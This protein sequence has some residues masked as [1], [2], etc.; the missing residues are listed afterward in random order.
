MLCN[1]LLQHCRAHSAP[2]RGNRGGFVQPNKTILMHVKKMQTRGWMRVDPHP[3]LFLSVSPGTSRDVRVLTEAGVL[4]LAR[5]LWGHSCSPESVSRVAEPLLLSKLRRFMSRSWLSTL[6]ARGKEVNKWKLMMEG[7][8]G[9]RSKPLQGEVSR[10][11]C[12]FNLIIQECHLVMTFGRPDRVDSAWAH[13]VHYSKY[14]QGECGGPYNFI[15]GSLNKS[16]RDV[17]GN[18]LCNIKQFWKFSPLHFPL[19]CYSIRWNVL[20]KKQLSLHPSL[21]IMAS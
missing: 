3:A 11:R 6:D 9:G 8:K 19:H 14:T 4:S 21:I 12:T 13:H 10:W 15:L 18:V 2:V 17:D 16:W 1:T 7:R 5:G 20:R